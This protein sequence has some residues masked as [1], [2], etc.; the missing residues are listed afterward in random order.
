M[1]ARGWWPLVALAA[2]LLALQTGCRNNSGTTPFVYYHGSPWAE[3]SV[4]GASGLFLLDTGASASV[5]DA[6]LAGRAGLPTTGG[7]SITATTG[8]VDVGTGRVERLELAGRTHT[9]RHV[10]VQDLGDFRAP[11]GR[12]KSGLLGSDFFL[13]YTLT[14]D[15]ERSRMAL[16]RSPGPSASGMT[17]HRMRLNAGVPTVQVFFG[18]GAQAPVWAKFDTG[19]SYADER[20]VHLE[21]TPAR[22]RALLGEDYRERPAGR[23][24]V[25][26][27]AGEEELLLF[28]YGP[29]RLLGREFE[30]VRL[31]VHEHEQGAFADPEAVLISGSVLRQF[32]RV[33]LDFPRRTVWVK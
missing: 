17:P 14:L 11:G 8:R 27:L 1:S 12:R 23:L 6:E 9:G 15:M 19:S 3:G 31:I 7:E 28:E 13:E 4:N 33:D 30:S 2:V 16:R 32:D 25:L 10:L 22:A 29:V 20:I 24:R 18:D 5:V 21:V 26:S